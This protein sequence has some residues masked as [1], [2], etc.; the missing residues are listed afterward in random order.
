ML[1][2]VT[3]Y[4]YPQKVIYGEHLFLSVSRGVGRC[5]SLRS[6]MQVLYAYMTD[7]N[8]NPGTWCAF[9]VSNTSQL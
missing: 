8:K 6:I 5:W 3:T 4:V 7:P 9:L 2:H 1:Y